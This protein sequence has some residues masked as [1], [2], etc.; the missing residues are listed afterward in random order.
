[1]IFRTVKEAHRRFHSFTKRNEE[2]ALHPNIR[3]VVFEIVLSYG[4]GNEEFDSILKY[5]SE[6]RTADQKVVALTGLG[7]AQSDDLIQR[8][9]K[10][11]TSEEVRN[12]D[13]IY[14]FNGYGL[15]LFNHVFSVLITKLAL[16]FF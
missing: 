3:G 15:F 10:F 8:A 14:A 7:F 12:Q 13:I 9:L 2:S 11:S 6:A 4:G 1:V 5:Y 16:I